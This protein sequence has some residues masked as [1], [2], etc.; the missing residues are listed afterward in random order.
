ME[1]YAI[2][3][4]A[5]K[6]FRVEK[7]KV[8]KVPYLHQ[9]VGEAVEFDRVLLLDNG[10]EVKI[11]RPMVEGVKVSAKVLEHGREKKVVVF[12]KKR[13]KGYRV[14]RGHRQNFTKIQIENIA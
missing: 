7:D 9:P 12:K 10:E 6:Q 4:I 2:V 11:G 8:V 3:E 1:M 5:G 14:K 13:R